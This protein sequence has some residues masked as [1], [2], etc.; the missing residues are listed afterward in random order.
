M[1]LMLVDT[2][3]HV[4]IF[5]LAATWHAQC[6]DRHSHWTATGY[7]QLMALNSVL[8]QPAV[9]CHAK[10]QFFLEVGVSVAVRPKPIFI[11]R[12]ETSTA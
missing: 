5:K 6:S 1:R 10:C 4:L 7:T 11:A 2:Q 9:G 12:R 8:L 3:V